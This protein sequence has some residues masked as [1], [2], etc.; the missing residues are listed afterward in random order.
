M[1]KVYKHRISNYLNQ[2]L[3]ILNMHN[4]SFIFQPKSEITKHF[5]IQITKLV[6]NYI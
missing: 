5:V 2:F 3:C 1:Y 4:L 6:Y